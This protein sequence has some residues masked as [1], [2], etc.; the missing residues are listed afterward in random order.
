MPPTPTTTP[1]LPTLR[2]HLATHPL[3]TTLR[4]LP[5][6]RT[7][8]QHHVTAVW[9]FMSLLKS[10]QHDLAPTTTPWRPPADP[11]AARL[12]HEIVLDEESDRLP[13][14]HGHASHFTWYTEAMTELGADT[15]PIQ[16]FLHH[17]QTGRPHREA[18][19][20]SGLP[21]A[22]QH[23]TSTTLSFLTEPLPVR[24]AVF[25]HGREEL[26][27]QMFL[28][29]A[30]QMRAEGLPC[31]RFVAYLERHI[32]VDGGAHGA[33]AAALLERLCRAAPELHER[34]EAAAVRALEAR[35]Q[36]WDAVVAAITA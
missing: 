36:L 2:H 4:T 14:R 12:I 23:F 18:L 24:A 29:L 13:Y 10:L 31:G 34:A 15:A 32:E 7:F 27:P 35:L 33:H 8:T 19:A 1:T 25:L 9:D 16:R 28:P 5:H 3:Y 22:A 20:D 11:E 17:L 30:R 26:I 6:L 21:K